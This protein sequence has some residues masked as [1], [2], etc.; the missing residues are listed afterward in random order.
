MEPDKVSVIIPV[1]NEERYLSRCLSSV[2]RQEYKNLELIVVDDGSTDHSF[3]IANEF[4]NKVFSR[5]HKGPGNARNWGAKKA[6][7]GIL[8][9]VDADMV[10]DKDYVGNIIIPIVKKKAVATFTRQE[11]VLNY[12]NIWSR[13]WSINNDLPITRRLPDNFKNKERF[14][15][16]IKRDFFQK[17]EGFNTKLGYQDDKFF[18]VASKQ[19]VLAVD[20]AL[21]FHFNPDTLKDVFF[22]ARW[23]GRSPSLKR[24]FRNVMKYSFFNSLR[25]ITFSLKKKAPLRFIIFKIVFDFGILLGILFK[26][27]KNNYAK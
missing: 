5:E 25:N 23:I 16:A 18:N 14:F 4:T 6:T 10:L 22:S 13:C 27:N 7:G 26:N 2:R 3:E 15:R 20:S 12:D 11:L 24:N 9:F 21:C 19:Q 8:I 1:Y 17:N